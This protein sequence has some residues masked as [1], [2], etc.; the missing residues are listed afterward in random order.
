MNSY[1]LAADSRRWWWL[2]ATTGAIGTAAVTAIL[3]VP[4]TGHV[5]PAEPPPSQIGGTVTTDPGRVVD[6]P[7]YLARPGW[8]T[9]RGWEQPVCTTLLRRPVDDQGPAPAPGHGHGRPAPDYLP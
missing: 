5:A 8:N 4:A 3:V 7:C 6:R 9:V 2:P 1:S